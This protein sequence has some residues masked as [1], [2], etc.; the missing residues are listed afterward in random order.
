ME[1]LQKIIA[2]AGVSSRR[3]AEELISAGRVRV[4][5]KV[6]TELGTSAD[7]RTDRVEVDGKRLV[8][9]DFV[10]VVLHKPKN[11]VSTLSDPEARP[12]VREYLQAFGARLYPVGRLDFATSGVLLAT[13]DGD[14]ANGMLHPKGGVPKTYV[15][16][17][18]GVMDTPDLKR[19]EEGVDLEDG[20]TLPARV[21]VI[22][23]EADRTWFEITIREGRN[24]QI[25]R[26]G[27]AT[28]FLVMRLARV[29]FAGVTHE[30]L[31]P[32]Q[33]RQLTWQEL[34]ALKEAFG[35]PKRVPKGERDLEVRGRPTRSPRAT[36]VAPERSAARPEPR[37]PSNDPRSETR[38]PTRSAT[39]SN[40]RR[41]E[42]SRR[43]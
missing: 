7:P 34:S 23:R 2:R 6:V 8:R 29:S 22:R 24:Q 41:A 37:R 28:G 32:G 42:P 33:A 43:K 36:G 5:G 35:V 25:R 18:R 16:K 30:G 19:W 11:V 13:N 31:R 40:S 3:A 20:R 17:V 26:M 15:V 10:Y 14:F 39:K 38:K 1:R 9:E 27:E 4:N 21:S 12:T